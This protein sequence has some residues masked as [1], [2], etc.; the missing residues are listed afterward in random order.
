MI[1]DNKVEQFN[2]TA[3]TNKFDQ[4]RVGQSSSFTWNMASSL[5]TVSS[6]GSD[7]A[8]IGGDLAYQ[9]GLNGNL[10]AL[11]AQPALGI[12]GSNGFGSGSQALQSASALN[13]GFAVLY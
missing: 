6:G 1:H 7:T 9:Y 4:V 11:S 10:A 3:L 12:V 5:E 8:A 2:F 13:D